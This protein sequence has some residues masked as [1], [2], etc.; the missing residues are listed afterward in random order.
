MSAAG[1]IETGFVGA[2]LMGGALV[3]R[4]C[5]LG[6]AVAVCDIDPACRER[7]RAAGARIADT[8][9]GVARLLGPDGVLVLV[10]VDAVQCRDVLWGAHGAAAALQP[11]H[12]VLLC[13]TIAPEDTEAMAR[14]LATRGVHTID[15][16]MSGGPQRAL[17]GTMSLMVAGPDAVVARH[18]ALLADLAG[19]VFRVGD[20][21]G[22]GARTKLV[23][24]LLAGIHLAG[25]AEVLALA[26]R[27]GLD[28]ATT[29][30]VIEH[31]SGQSWIG[32]DRMRRRLAGDTAPRAH[33]GL[34]AKD[35]G[36]ALA[37]AR[38]IGPAGPLGEAAARVFAQA[39]DG[40]LAGADDSAL[41]DW[42]QA[43]PTGAADR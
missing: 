37:A 27:M 38:A 6:R 2:G 43:H 17:E 1:G 36:L 13:P 16:P 26:G 40:G 33:L 22:D 39:R 25:A 29:L 21:A 5:G 9:A 8:P 41:L 24:N 7:A 3:H 12:T 42:L 23:N 4:L 30:D 18:A 20:R 11:G 10:V 19:R 14:E 15:A 35:T 34:L 28:L 31:S 32:S